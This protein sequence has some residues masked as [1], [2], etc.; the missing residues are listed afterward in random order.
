M[1]FYNRLGIRTRLRSVVRRIWPAEPK[2]LILT[3][4]RIA[5][6]P[7]DHW[8]IAVSPGH[9]EEHLC[10][11]RRTR[12]PLPLT[13]FVRS[14]MAGTL[15]SNAV[16]LTFD[17]GYVDNLVA[18]KPRLATADV[19]ATVFLTTGY[20]DRPGEYWW[21]ELARLILL[22]SGPQHFELTVQGD[23]MSFDLD[24]ETATRVTGPKD[25]TPLARQTALKTIWQ[26][27][28]SIEDEEREPIMTELRSKFIGCNDQLNKGRAMTR[29]E[30]RALVS[31]GLV[32]I[33][34]HTVTH[35]V[36]ST[37]TADASRREITDSKRTCEAIIGAPVTSFAY[38]YGDFDDKAR[39][40]VRHAGFSFACSTQRG[41]TVATSD[42]F[43]L[44]RITVQNWN[45]DEFERALR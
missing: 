40:A 21:D 4:H 15:P 37:L 11:L 36:L 39:E 13:D 23:T 31:D 5:D 43:T 3:Y 32:T 20:V 16:A 25:V 9:F 18:G 6:D 41:P 7:V 1:S 45:G 30:V 33:G 17:D 2:P 19:P 27:L 8:R 28:R 29:E 42:L 44:P 22:G 34:A 24:A 10:V 14:L 35:P 26:V 38:P 12:L